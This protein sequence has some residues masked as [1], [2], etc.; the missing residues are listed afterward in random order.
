MDA[1]TPAYSFTD[2]IAQSDVM[3]TI[4]KTITKIADYKTTVL[5]TGE[6]GTGKELI[7]KAIHHNSSRRNMPM[8]D[9]KHF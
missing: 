1:E 9:V 2:I 7:A 4:F 6:S 8:I 3:Q 5:I